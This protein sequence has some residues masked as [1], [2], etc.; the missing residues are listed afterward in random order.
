MLLSHE[1][2]RGMTDIFIPVAT[3]MV[4]HF[5]RIRKYLDFRAKDIVGNNAYQFYVNEDMARVIKHHYDR[6]L[7]LKCPVEFP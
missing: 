6:K 3:D 5:F 4:H 7:L 2:W 1:F